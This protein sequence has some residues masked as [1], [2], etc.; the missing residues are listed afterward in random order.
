MNYAT[1]FFSRHVLWLKLA[2]AIYILAIPL[3]HAHLPHNWVWGIAVFFLLLMLLPYPL[4]AQAQGA[5]HKTEILVSTVLAAMGLLGLVA[6]P[7][8]IVSAIF[9]HGVWDLMKHRGA[10][11]NFFGWYL[12]GC[13][14]VDWLYAAALSTFLLSGADP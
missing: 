7:W 4:A 13:V 12:N 8:L 5:H 11:A 9:L 3:S 10:G 14:L 1:P 6:S 2:S